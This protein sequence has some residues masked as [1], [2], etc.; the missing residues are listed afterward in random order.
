MEDS[1]KLGAIVARM[2]NK[3]EHYDGDITDFTPISTGELDGYINYKMFGGG[4][5]CGYIG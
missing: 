2:E 5:G 4:S 3:K 1:L